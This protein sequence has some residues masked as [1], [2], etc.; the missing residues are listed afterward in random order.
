MKAKKAGENPP[1]SRQKVRVRGGQP[2]SQPKAGQ[3]KAVPD[4]VRSV[5]QN[6][7]KAP[8]QAPVPARVSRPSEPKVTLYR[9]TP[10][11]RFGDPGL[12]KIAA[13]ISHGIAKRGGTTVVASAALTLALRNSKNIKWRNATPS[14]WCEAVLSILLKSLAHRTKYLNFKAEGTTIVFKAVWRMPTK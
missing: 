12:D 14:Q 1:T 10:A 11:P 7:K 6:G 9:H 4:G 3:K 5:G 2:P 13:D 8:P